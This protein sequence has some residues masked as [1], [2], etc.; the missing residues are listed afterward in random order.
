M[1]LLLAFEG[2][3]PISRVGGL[4]TREIGLA[5]ALAASGEKTTLAFLGDPGEPRE[6]VRNGVRLCRLLPDLQRRHPGGPYDAEW[7]KVGAL[8]ASFPE[9]AFETFIRPAAADGERVIL[10]AE[11]WQTVPAVIRLSDLAHERGARHVLTVVWNANNPFG[12]QTI[13]WPRLDFVAHVTTV[14][15]WMKEQIR[16]TTGL[17]AV[18]IPNGLGDDAFLPVPEEAAA[19]LRQAMA[20]PFWAKIGRYDPDKRWEMALSALAHARTAGGPVR[21]LV[22]GGREPYRQ[23]L[24]AMARSLSLDW[25][26][27]RY[28]P[29]WPQP[30]RSSRAP[31]VEV[32][33]FL[34]DPVVRSIYRGAEAVLANSRREPF[35]LV[36]LEVM[37]AGGVAVV[38]STGEDYARPYHN[39]LVVETEDPRE[40][41]HHLAYLARPGVRETLV[42]RGRET[43]DDYRWPNVLDVLT[44]FLEYFRRVEG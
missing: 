29:D 18:V 1:Y 10:L 25:D 27:V 13:D 30:L 26:E 11:E 22:R 7:A 19:D 43:A 28:G 12:F 16:Q 38:G 4:A 6:A 23:H 33:N 39:A 40:I 35:G 3:D 5:E 41:P 8:A 37:A 9:W 44:S 34:P 17:S 32:V 42:R 36:G 21:L 14:S 2:P 24:R 20:A 31:V 15:R